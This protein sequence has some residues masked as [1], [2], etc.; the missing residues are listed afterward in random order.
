MVIALVCL[1]ISIH[2]EHGKLRATCGVA[3]LI[4]IVHILA[5]PIDLPSVLII[6]VGYF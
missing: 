5:I 1:L 6:S 4:P 2:G 3:E